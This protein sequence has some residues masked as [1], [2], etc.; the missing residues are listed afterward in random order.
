MKNKSILILVGIVLISS[1]VGGFFVF[2]NQNNQ[3]KYDRVEKC[4]NEPYGVEHLFLNSQITI[5][6]NILVAKQGDET[7]IVLE[8]KD[9]NKTGIT[10]YSYAYTKGGIKIVYQNRII[11][12]LRKQNLIKDYITTLINS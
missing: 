1:V 9:N 11:I 10:D 4:A 3:Y 2:E 7:M 6:N 12:Y 8:L 5:K